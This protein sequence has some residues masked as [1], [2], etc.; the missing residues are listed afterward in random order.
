[1]ERTI[2]GIWIQLRRPNYRACGCYEG[3]GD[4]RCLRVSFRDGGGRLR[5]YLAIIRHSA[6]YC[7]VCYRRFSLLPSFVGDNYQ[8]IG[9]F[10]DPLAFIRSHL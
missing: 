2:S 4:A 5:N 3:R 10:G 7:S 6:G 8:C 9:V 1:M